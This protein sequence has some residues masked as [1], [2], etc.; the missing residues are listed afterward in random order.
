MTD[1]IFGNLILPENRLQLHKE[2]LQGVQ[3]T[4]RIEPLDPTPNLPIVF[5]LRTGGPV[6]CDRAR[7]FYTLD[8]RDPSGPDARVLDLE[9]NQSTWDEVTWSY[10][11]QWSV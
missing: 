4:H 8:D 1:N 10:I 7:M 5:T 2:N 6:P 11:R 3:H 9:L